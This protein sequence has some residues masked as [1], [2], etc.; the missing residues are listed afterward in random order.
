MGTRSTPKPNSAVYGLH[1]DAELQ[2]LSLPHT[3]RGCPARWAGTSTSH[4]AADC[5]LT[6]TSPSAFD[7]HRDGKTGACLPPERVGLVA[8]ERAGY[9][10]WGRPA[11]EAAAER[12][13]AL[14]AAKGER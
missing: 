9:T 13:R 6:F 12:L 4:C 2:V 10:A 7:A 1:R 3:C 14:R 11:D 8:F 5:H